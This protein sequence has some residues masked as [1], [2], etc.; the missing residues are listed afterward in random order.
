MPPQQ[1]IV[2][3][4]ALAR[5]LTKERKEGKKVA[6]C[7]GVFDLLHPGH[8]KHLQAAKKFADYLVVTVTADDFV[9]KGPDRPFFNQNLRSEVLASLE[10]V[11]FVAIVKSNTAIES[12]KQIKPNFY[13]KGPDYK[14]R[15]TRKEIPTRLQDEEAAVEAMGG[16][17]V[18]TDD[19]LFSSSRL[20]NEY[21]ENYPQ[22]TK[23]FLQEYKQK[24][25]SEEIIDKLINLRN[26][27]ILVI[28]DA[29]IDQ[30]QYCLPMGKS[31][32]EPII[33]HKFIS[34]ESFIGGAIATAN[35]VAA[36]SG[37]VH[38]LTVLGKRNSFD[39]FIMKHLK[40]EIK[41]TFYYWEDSS[42]IIKR[43]F[44]DFATKQK[45]FQIS[46]IKDQVIP[47]N[48]ENKIVNFLRKNIH[49]YDIVVVNDF[50]HGLMTRRII[51]T[52]CSRA[53]FLAINV[54]ANSANYGFN[55][56]TKYPRAD[57]VC[58]DEQELR[59][60]TH[61]KYSPV[62][63]LIKEIYKRMK[64]TD[65]VVTRGPDGASCYTSERKMVEVPSFTQ[66]IVDRMGA[67]D[68]LFAVTTP[69]VF[70]GMDRESAVFIG[71]VA[72]AYQVQSIGNRTS[73][74]LEDLSKFIT[75]LLK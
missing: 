46:M 19:V 44:V 57:F 10:C 29:I 75:R 34:E 61:D 32:K 13:V 23:K 40:P 64:C 54:Q 6:L 67:G 55:V 38:L 3:L 53:K 9:R 20:L 73:L 5:L 31:S 56:I 71:N 7:H 25:T 26:I 1:K 22:K 51:R 50:G 42:T 47:L 11:D 2:D 36:L 66:K 62:E 45:L 24:T 37:S 60:A 16:R 49:D 65:M 58:I 18:Y 4:K 30:Y 33:V 14:N 27:K 41:C 17:L 15:K 72:G 68:T 39:R 48:L 70:R 52:I 28:G 8:I 21:F 43:R 74:T 35:H 12:I 69:C 63:L 59:L